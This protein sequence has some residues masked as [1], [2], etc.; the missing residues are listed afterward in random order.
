MPETVREAV[1]RES[2]G[3]RDAGAAPPPRRA[4]S[5]RR[6]DACAPPTG[7][8]SSARSRCFAATGQPLVVV[9][10]AS[11]SRGRSPA[12]RL[13]K[14]FLAPDRDELRAADRRALRRHD[15]GRRPRRG[16]GARGRAAR[17]DAAGH[18][19]PWRAGPSRPSARRDRR[20]TRRS[21]G[22]R[23]IRAATPSASSPGS[24][25]RCPDWTW[26]ERRR[27]GV[28]GRDERG[29]SAPARRVNIW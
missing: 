18:A 12:C 4:R 24:A 11:A 3:R 16:A 14:L 29:L 10:R 6:P 28:R 21:R 25:T 2:E 19:G 27:S 20:S 26:V 7:C 23:P 13:V 1:R 17:S 15:G 5:R 22:D 8:A 9:P